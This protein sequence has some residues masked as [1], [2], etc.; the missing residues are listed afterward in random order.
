MEVRLRYVV[1][2]PSDVDRSLR[3]YRDAL[4]LEVEHRDEGYAALRVEGPVILALM[5]RGRLPELLPEEHCRPPEAGRHRGE[6]AFLVE[7]ADAAHERLTEQGVEFLAP[8]ADRP[9]GERTAYLTDPDGYLVEIA[10]KI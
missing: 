4:G 10:E 5:D 7:D 1:R 6:L 8:P 3:F 2:F 9:W